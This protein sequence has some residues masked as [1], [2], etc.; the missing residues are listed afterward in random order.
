VPYTFPLSKPIDELVCED[1]RDRF[2]ILCNLLER[3][4]LD[5]ALDNPSKSFTL[6]APVNDAFIDLQ[7]ELDV[8]V[9]EFTNQE[10]AFLLQGHG[11]R[12]EFFDDDLDCDARLDMINGEFTTTRCDDGKFQVGEGNTPLNAP[13]IIRADQEAC[14]GVI[15]VI[16]HVILPSQFTPAPNPD[17]T[18]HPTPHPTDE[19]TPEPTPHPTDEQTPEPTSHPTPHPTDEDTPQPTPDPTPHPTDEQ[20]PEPTPDPTP[21][22][23]DEQTPEP[24]PE[25]TPDP[26]PQPTDC[27][28]ICKSAVEVCSFI[29]SATPFPV[30]FGSLMHKSDHCCCCC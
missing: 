27:S 20:T 1:N 8:G 25:P 30:L 23:T 26:T 12:G 15:H 29:L 13:R 28:T 2:D 18:P 24:A 7:D 19:Q 14:N 9:E 17:P 6:F 21:H 3:T 4:N 10:L 22:P 5:D 16:D 11:A